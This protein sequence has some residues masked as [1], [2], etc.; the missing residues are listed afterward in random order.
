MKEKTVIFG[1]IM[2]FEQTLTR[3]KP[4]ATTRNFRGVGIRVAS[5]QGGSEADKYGTLNAYVVTLTGT[6]ALGGGGTFEFGYVTTTKNYAQYYLSLYTTA[7]IAAT[8]ST[9][10]GLIRANKGQN[11]TFSDWAGRSNS[12]NGSYGIAGYSLGLNPAYTSHAL[13]VGLGFQYPESASGSG[14]SGKTFLIGSPINC[15]PQ[16]TNVPWMICTYSY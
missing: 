5:S 8:I 9:G 6:L 7:G 1:S 14:S 3:C 11:P 10:A 13:T 16:P 2:F 12:L 15:N 4:T